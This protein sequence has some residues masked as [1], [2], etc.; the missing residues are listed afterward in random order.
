[1]KNLVRQR[2]TQSLLLNGDFHSGMAGWGGSATHVEVTG[3]NHLG[4][5]LA[6]APTYVADIPAEAEIWQTIANSDTYLFPSRRYVTKA[7]MVPVGLSTYKIVATPATRMDSAK[8]TGGSFLF[9]DSQGVVSFAPGQQIEVIDL[10]RTANGGPYRVGSLYSDGGLEV[11]PIEHGP[12]VLANQDSHTLTYGASAASGSIVLTGK[13]DFSRGEDIKGVDTGVIPGDIIVLDDPAYAVALVVSVATSSSATTCQVAPLSGFTFLQ[14]T[15]G[16][17]SNPVSAS[18]SSWALIPRTVINFQRDIEVFQYGFTLALSHYPGTYDGAPR[19]EFVGRDG[20]PIFD[21]PPVSVD[22]G[23]NFESLALTDTGDTA[24][25]RRIYRFFLET[26]Y[27]QDADIR[28]VIPGGSEGASIGDIALYRG[29]YYRRHDFDDR[30]DPTTD[31]T[32]DS[33]VAIDRLLPGADVVGSVIPPG[34]VILYTGGPVC[35]PGFKRCDGL[36]GASSSG[37]EVLPSPD[38]MTYDS[39]RNRTILEWDNKDFPVLNAV[40]QSTLIEGDSEVVSVTLPAAPPFYG[41]AE[42]V[43]FGPTHQRPQPG[44]SL[45]VRVSNEGISP[46]DYSVPVRQALVERTT[47]IGFPPVS[48]GN[49]NYISYPLFMS[50]SEFSAGESLLDP[51]GPPEAQQPTTYSKNT[52]STAIGVKGNPAPV[53]HIEN[54][55]QTL[56]VISVTATGL[57]TGELVYFRWSTPVGGSNS[58]PI[59]GGFVA[60]VISNQAGQVTIERADGASMVVDGV[61]GAVSGSGYFSDARLFGSDVVVTRT[62][63]ADAPVWSARRFKT[64]TK[65]TVFSDVTEDVTNNNSAGITLEPSGFVRY[66]DGDFDL[67]SMGHSHAIVRGDAVLDENA[68]PRVSQAYEY[69]PATQVAREHGHGFM[70][71]YH[72]VIPRFF[73]AIPCIKL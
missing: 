15:G 6:A 1:M 59:T 29:H 22:G 57:S 25:T 17:P 41:A 26:R 35:P 67:G 4:E 18:S 47:L 64:V 27:I 49:Q 34:T 32:P 56:V 68:A 50:A 40:G 8:L 44:M 55:L 73:A 66:G 42:A 11:S 24:F 16:G 37:T 23:L 63:V 9:Q 46:Y 5:N 51:I 3:Q 70:T 43:T 61:V 45:R 48:P 62:V 54:G 72:H 36:V 60:R 19:M 31:P 30:D 14:D 20:R 13:T 2:D 52:L 69:L 33:R 53:G 12:T 10:V 65:I 7:E 28:I 58:T 21:I 38:R 71:K 39:A